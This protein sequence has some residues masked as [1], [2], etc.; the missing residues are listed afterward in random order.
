MVWWRFIPPIPSGKRLQFANLKMA[1]ES[2]LI[3]Q[4]KMVIFHS[5]VNVYQRVYNTSVMVSNMRNS[6]NPWRV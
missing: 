2:S 4:F 6:L 1:I 5:Y 3:Y